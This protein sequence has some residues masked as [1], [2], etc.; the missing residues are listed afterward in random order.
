[1][2]SKW[3]ECELGDFIELKRGYDLPKSTRNEGSIPIISSSGFTDFHDKPMVK[4]PG[5]VTGRYGTIGEVFYSEEDFWPLNT[6]LYVVDF[7]A[8]D[9]LFVYYLLQTISYADYTDKAAV[10]GVNRNHLHKAKV[11]V[12]ISL[13]IQQ[14]VA[15]QLYQ[16]EKRVALSKQINQ[17]LEQMSQT[18]F[19]SWF[20]DFDPVIDNALDVGNPIPEALQ[21]RAELRQKVRNSA[22]FKPLPADIRALFPAEFEETELGWVP[23]GW[24]FKNL[25]SIYLCLDSKRIPLSKQERCQKQPGNIPYYGAT[26]VMDYI[27]EYIFDDILLLVGE[28]GSV[29]KDDNTPFIQYIWGKTWVNN[30]AHVLKGKDNISTEQLMLFMSQCNIS[31]FVTGAVQM[32]I[33]QKN[34]GSIQFL[35]A[36]DSINAA[37]NELIVP[38]FQ[39]LRATKEQLSDLINLRDTLLPKL[40]SGEL[41]LEDLPD[42]VTQTEPA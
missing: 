42:L 10:P 27:N 28:D 29:I 33:N 19:K 12:P 37:F 20:V 17:T 24:C 32:K 13:D 30:H 40:I 23:K 2:G 18:L 39:K 41:S 5:V 34:M 31:A 25:S 15:A 7:K 9:P 36:P 35:K 16:L 22:D 1:M 14:K 26:S 11:K 6:T 21:S 4:G 8:N 38:F 3:I